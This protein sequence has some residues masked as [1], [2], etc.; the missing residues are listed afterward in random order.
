MRL[1]ALLSW[2]DENPAWLAEVVA[3]LAGTVDHIVAVDGSYALYPEAR[4]SSGT[5][6]ADAVT[7]T[8]QGARMGVTLHV[9]Q[10]P[11]VGNEVE[12]RTA[13]FALGHLAAEP[14]ED[15][16]VV[17]DA[18]E[19]WTHTA[20]LRDALA[21]TDLDVAEVLL[22]ERVAQGDHELN[23]SMIRKCFRAQPDGIRLVG[24]HCHYEA[25]VGALW[26]SHGPQVPAEQLMDVRVR[27]RPAG[28]E[29]Y[30]TRRRLAYY[31]RRSQFG[32]E[33]VA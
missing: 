24:T 26:N 16:L 20:G 29:A 30:R 10:W 22:Y 33:V 28:R 27:H 15:W 14:G 19:V 32:A 1:V 25:A 12:K 31:D 8:A 21:R 11:W 13:M 23:R 18:D 5:E 4:G 3:S 2:F 7:G 17:V 6:Q 9:P